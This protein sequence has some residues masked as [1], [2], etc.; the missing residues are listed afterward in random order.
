MR[1][2]LV[3]I[4]VLTAAA[5]STG[6]T[7]PSGEGDGPGSSLNIAGSWTGSFSSSNLITEPITMQL[8]QS[9]ATIT[10]TW[11]GSEVAWEGQVT[12]TLNSGSFSGQLTFRGTA[13]NGAICTGTASVSGSA[14][15]TQ[16]SWTSGPG[17]VGGA[18]PAPL[19]TGIAIELHR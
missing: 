4:T 10:G 15:A 11:D 2:L 14:S 1:N 3:L 5:C 16:L 7:A 8:T 12:G 13:L 9:S 18:C 19:P 17:V 6:A